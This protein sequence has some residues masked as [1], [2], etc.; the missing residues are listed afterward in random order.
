MGANP[1]ESVARALGRDGDTCVFPSNEKGNV[2]D[3]VGFGY[4]IGPSRWLHDQEKDA[5]VDACIAQHGLDHGAG[6]VPAFGWGTAS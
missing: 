4:G 3:F 6:L 2:L 1:S 5:Y